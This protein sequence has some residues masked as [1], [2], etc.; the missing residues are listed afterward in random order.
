MTPPKARIPIC[1]PHESMKPAHWDQRIT[2]TQATKQHTEKQKS[3]FLLACWSFPN[4]FVQKLLTVFPLKCSI[5]AVFCQE[6]HKHK[7]GGEGKTDSHCRIGNGLESTWRV[8]KIW[9]D[10]R[11]RHQGWRLSQLCR[12]QT[13]QRVRHTAGSQESL[14]WRTGRKILIWYS[15]KSGH[16]EGGQ[17]DKV[18]DFFP[19][20]VPQG[21][22]S[23]F[24]SSYPHQRL[25][26]NKKGKEG[27][28]PTNTLTL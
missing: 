6:S 26:C 17:R 11:G 24:E 9:L 4:L 21:F 27:N 16:G 22:S 18:Y 28:I 25:M 10:A 20:T 23:Q 8:D 2:H 14:R 3:A 19:L 1:S 13:C 12:S 7:Y 15:L 5:H